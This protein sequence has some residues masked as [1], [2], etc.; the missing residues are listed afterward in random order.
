MTTLTETITE[1]L[2]KGDSISLPGFGH[3]RGTRA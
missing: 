1:I 3:L 2:Q